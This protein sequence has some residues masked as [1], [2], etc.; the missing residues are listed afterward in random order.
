MRQIA[1]EARISET[2]RATATSRTGRA[3][4]EFEQGTEGTLP[5][6]AL[7]PQL[8]IY[9]ALKEGVTRLQRSFQRDVS[10]DVATMFSEGL[11][12]PQRLDLLLDALDH[13]N[14]QRIARRR[15]GRGVDSGLAAIIGD[16]AGKLTGAAAN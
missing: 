8:F 5:R 11:E 9:N 14:T 15:F 4:Q 7:T 2:S 16:L 13:A 3:L 6:G 10:D 12:D 1:A